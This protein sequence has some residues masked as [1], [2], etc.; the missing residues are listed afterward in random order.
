MK[1]QRHECDGSI[2]QGDNTSG[3][4]VVLRPIRVHCVGVWISTGLSGVQLNIRIL[5]GVQLTVH[6]LNFWCT[7][8]HTYT[9]FRRL[10]ISTYAA[11]SGTCYVSRRVSVLKQVGEKYWVTSSEHL[12]RDDPVDCRMNA[13]WRDTYTARN[14]TRETLKKHLVIESDFEHQNGGENNRRKEVKGTW[15]KSTS[16]RLTLL[17]LNRKIIDY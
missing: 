9:Q 4:A 11:S 13:I 5:S 17:S 16:G 1:K 7:V 8:D 10:R 14:M 6:I 12:R 2:L 3:G 15:K